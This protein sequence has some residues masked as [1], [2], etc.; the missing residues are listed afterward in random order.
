MHNH[1]PARQAHQLVYPP[2]QTSAFLG[3]TSALQQPSLPSNS[4]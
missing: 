2:Q 3:Q 4:T 1:Q